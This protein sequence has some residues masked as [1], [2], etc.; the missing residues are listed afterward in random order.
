[1]MS[2]HELSEEE[3]ALYGEE[4]ADPAPAIANVGKMSPTA[5][6]DETS[7]A[8]AQTNIIE[9]L[10][11]SAEENNAIEDVRQTE[12]GVGAD[13]KVSDGGSPQSSESPEISKDVQHSEHYDSQ[14][15]DHRD[16]AT[17]ATRNAD[18]KKTTHLP[19]VEDASRQNKAQADVL[20]H[21]NENE[22]A[23]NSEEADE[24]EADEDE[25]DEDEEDEDEEEDDDFDV[26]INAG[27]AAGPESPAAAAVDGQIGKVRLSG[28]ASRWQR[29]GFTAPDRGVPAT[30]TA[31]PGGVLA[32]LPTPTHQVGTN[33]KSVYDTEFAKL[34]EKPWLDRGADI[35]EYFNYGFNEET[36]KLYCE[37]QVQMRLEASMLAKIKTVDGDAGAVGSAQSNSRQQSSHGGTSLQQTRKSQ[38]LS[39]QAP[40][41]MQSKQPLQLQS[42][43]PPAAQPPQ[44]QAS[45]LGGV[46]VPAPQSQDMRQNAMPMP[47]IGAQPGIQQQM[48]PGGGNMMPG[49][50]PPGLPAGV[51]FPF[52]QAPFP[53]PPNASGAAGR[54]RGAA[55]FPFHMPPGM[56]M[57]PGF[58]GIPPGAMAQHGVGP[59]GMKAGNN[60]AILQA[61][62]GPYGGAAVDS[63]GIRQ[64]IIP[65]NAGAGAG[66]RFG[67]APGQQPM[68]GP[69]AGSMDAMGM[70]DGDGRR[71]GG[72]H[73][74]PHGMLGRNNVP[75]MENPGL[76][77]RFGNDPRTFMNVSNNG[78]DPTRVTGQFD[79][80]GRT[81][82][83][84][85]R[86]AGGGRFDGSRSMRDDRGDDN[87][88]R[89]FSNRDYDDRYDERSKRSRW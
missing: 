50:M 89:S 28:S 81:L 70:P 53:M 55:P 36:W 76:N 45:L 82:N 13:A 58:P 74:R 7:S 67:P 21:A 12:K 6:D 38:A 32:M 66:S 59:R 9:A 33:Q 22:E 27:D 68:L 19:G 44:H 17:N 79:D 62:G 41:N 73:P 48:G 3:A 10:S 57:P 8:K 84:D 25:E 77:A 69:G 47:V 71:F 18:V 14:N 39:N 40:L 4:C 52:A 5:V 64:K 20:E 46:Q 1:M 80:R 49:G 51:P 24:D 2:D 34:T 72:S 31:R 86:S 29:P 11:N 78:Y 88:K 54:G 75:H 30:P 87:R 63:G 37:R 16:P 35:T 43:R 61:D 42:Q 26:V 83:D 85:P 23:E 56:P 60:Q 15:G 65:G